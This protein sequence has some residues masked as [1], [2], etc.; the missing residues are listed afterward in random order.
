MSLAMA[1]RRVW[2]SLAP[3]ERALLALMV[4]LLLAALV[5]FAA[6]APALR[7]VRAA[8]AQIAALDQQWVSMQNLATQARGMQARSAVSRQDA[9]R[10][11]ETAVLQRLGAAGK[12]NVS[13]DRATVVLQGAAPQAMAAWLSQARLQGRVVVSQAS[14]TRGP[15][16]WDGTVVFQLP[17]G[18]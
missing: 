11:L 7:T 3:R 9:L 14:L 16:G 5:W 1:S 10:E 8:P 17:A 2:R 15:A 6:I 18:P 4:C 13:A 12:V